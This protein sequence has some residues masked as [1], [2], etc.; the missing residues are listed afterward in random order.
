[1]SMGYGANYADVVEDTFV[2]KTCPKEHAAF[3]KSYIEAGTDFESVAQE[4]TFE[5][6][7]AIPLKIRKA[8]IALT[9]AFNK[10]T[11][12]E[13]GIG[14]HS[15]ED[16]GDRYDEVSGGYWCVDGVWKRTP[17]GNKYKLQITRSFYV[18]FG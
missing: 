6:R 5:G 12:L 4:I 7:K 14:Y 9:K 2:K 3:L 17:A 1:M 15:I 10:K 11:G 8:Y 13:L 16:S 18:T